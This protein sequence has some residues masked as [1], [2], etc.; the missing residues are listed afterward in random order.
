[1][2]FLFTF[3]ISFVK[4][5]DYISL[6]LVIALAFLIVSPA[7]AKENP[8]YS[9][10]PV[11]AV[12]DGKPVTLDDIRDKKIHDLSNKLYQQLE[13]TLPEYAL[14]E[15]AK[16]HK[17]INLNPKITITDKQVENF[18]KANNLKKRGSLSQFKGQIRG[19]LT[20]Q[21]RAEHIYTQYAKALNK[22]WIKSY[23]EPPTEFVVTADVKTAY[24]RGNPKA[25]VMILE[26]SDYQC[27]YCSRIQNSI[28]NLIKKYN[29]TVAYGYRH[30]PLSF[31]SEADE[32]AI[33]AE[34]A[35]EQGKFEEMHKVLFRNQKAQHPKDLK[36]YARR[37]K[38]KNPRKFDECLDKERYRD[39]VNQ[40]IQDGA[41]LG[42]TGTP[43]F[44]VGFYDPKNKV[45]RGEVF[46]G[47]HPQERFEKLIR[48]YLKK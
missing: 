47:A 42:I 39:L 36:R 8:I 33:A 14:R 23:I 15:L 5:V 12:I 40:D 11:L 26:F 37:I 1:M 6:I 21:Y 48:K 43:G 28:G 38:V 17:D 32:A 19:Y 24:V 16:K 27:P 13:N 35:R 30:F 7:A 46:S 41:A 25:S 20:Q 34:C 45:L 9:S 4:F 18:Y 22:G 44:I 31:H 3:S 10:N 2:K 29:K